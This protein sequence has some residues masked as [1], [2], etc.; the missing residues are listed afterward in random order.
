MF[1]LSIGLLAILLVAPAHAQLAVETAPGITF[2]GGDTMS[3]ETL[4]G[5]RHFSGAVNG[6]AVDIAPGI[7]SYSL[8]PSFDAETDQRIQEIE[9]QGAETR[10]WF[11]RDAAERAARERRLDETLRSYGR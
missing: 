3:V 4:P 10:A 9:R 7:T 11:Q 1:F 8:R 2:Y 5:V 6:T